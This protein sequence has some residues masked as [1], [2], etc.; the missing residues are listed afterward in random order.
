MDEPNDCPLTDSRQFAAKRASVLAFARALDR[1][2]DLALA[3]DLALDRVLDRSLDR[4]L[5]RARDLDLDRALA[6]DLDRDLARDRVLARDLDLARDRVLAR[7]LDLARD[8]DLALALARDLARDRARDRDLNSL[9]VGVDGT[10]FAEQLDGLRYTVPK[11]GAPLE[12]YQEFVNRLLQL[13]YDTFKLNPTL[14]DL[15]AG[16]QTTIDTYLYMNRLMVQCQQEASRVSPQTWDAIL[17][18]MLVPAEAP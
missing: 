15:M 16:E 7:D 17:A 6:R 4:A 13:Y 1:S 5:A 8:R 11:E 10:L 18:T 9:F 3:L 2:R 12:E 14:L